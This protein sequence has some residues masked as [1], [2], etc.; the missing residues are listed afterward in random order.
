MRGNCLEKI[1][2]K[3]LRYQLIGC[4]TCLVLSSNSDAATNPF[5]LLWGRTAPTEIIFAPFGYHIF[6]PANQQYV[7]H[8]EPNSVNNAQYLLAFHWKSIVAVTFSNSFGD[9]VELLGLYR[10]IVYIKRLNLAYMIGIM[11]GYGSRADNLGP[12]L[13]RSIVASDPGVVAALDAD[14]SLTKKI[15]FHMFC[16]VDFRSIDFG[17]GYTFS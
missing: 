2:T 1:F 8:K 14:F 7:F 17:I 9:Q 12:P 6:D 4:L 3:H 11:T 5:A 13:T 16:P 10:Q 15:A